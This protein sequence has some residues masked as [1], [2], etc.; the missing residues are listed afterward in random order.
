MDKGQYVLGYS[1]ARRVPTWVAWRLTRADLGAEDRADDFRADDALPAAFFKVGPSA[2]EGS[3]YDRGH[4]CPSAHRTASRAAN[5][6]TFLMTNMQPQ[7]HALNAGP[8][9]SLESRERRLAEDGKVVFVIA[10]GI[11]APDPP[12]IGPGIHVPASGYRITVVL[13][14]GEGHVDVTPETDL[15]ASIL[16]NS[17]EAKGRKWSELTTSVDQ[18]EQQTG[19]DFLSKLSD[20]VENALEAR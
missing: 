16:P 14:P 11:F 2:Y 19:Y 13:E 20:D 3:G 10:G 8:W 6:L 15:V 4:M 1:D 12:K 5:S 7:S 17:S 18:I 9:K